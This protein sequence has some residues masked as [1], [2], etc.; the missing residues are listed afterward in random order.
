MEILWQECALKGDPEN[1][2]HTQSIEQ[3]INLMDFPPPPQGF[4]KYLRK[5]VQDSLAPNTFYDK[6]MFVSKTAVYSMLPRFLSSVK[7]NTL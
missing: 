1:I 3:I 5:Y 7:Y 4:F 2:P 6:Q